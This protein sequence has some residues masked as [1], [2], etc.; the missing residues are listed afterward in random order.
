MKCV[1]CNGVGFKLEEFA[2]QTSR[3]KLLGVVCTTCGG[4][5]A[6]MDYENIGAMLDRQKAAFKAIAD[7]L[8]VI[9][10]L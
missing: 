8:G 6:V 9:V 7:R 1:K 10:D 3:Y 5:H 4:L 2:P